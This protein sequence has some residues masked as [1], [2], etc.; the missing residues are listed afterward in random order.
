M[1]YDNNMHNITQHLQVFLSY[2]ASERTL[3]TKGEAPFTL[4]MSWP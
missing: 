4:L 2:M 1:K 3:C